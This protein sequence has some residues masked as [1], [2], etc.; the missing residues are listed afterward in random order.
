MLP[1]VTHNGYPPCPLNPGRRP[2]LR[3]NYV[4]ARIA[5]AGRLNEGRAGRF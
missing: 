4:V 3:M 2:I 1:P 5:I